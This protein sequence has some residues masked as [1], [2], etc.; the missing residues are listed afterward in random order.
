MESSD[1][2]DDSVRLLALTL[3]E[4]VPGRGR[5]GVPMGSETSLRMPVLAI[6]WLRA[7]VAPAAFGDATAVVRRVRKVKSSAEIL[8][9]R[10]ACGL[11]ARAFARL[12]EIARAGAGARAEVEAV[13]LSCTNLRTLD[14]IDE[15]ERALD[16]PV[17]SSNQALAWQMARLAA[18]GPPG[19]TFGRLMAAE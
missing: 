12:P 3:L 8:K 10:A 16:K 5:S 17:V 1:L 19:K 7:A 11:A 2:V 4:L 6:E 13:L 14:V 9:I 15:V 18:V